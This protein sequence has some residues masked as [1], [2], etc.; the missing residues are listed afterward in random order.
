MECR[1]L[2]P[3]VGPMG[4][5]KLSG[6][7]NF[8]QVPFSV[9]RMFK[10]QN[11]SK[12]A[13]YNKLMRLASTVDLT[14][15]FCTIMPVIAADGFETRKCAIP[16]IVIFKGNGQLPKK[17]LAALN[18]ISG[19]EVMFSLKGVFSKRLVRRFVSFLKRWSFDKEGMNHNT[20]KLF[21]ANNLSC[22]DSNKAAGKL[23]E[24]LLLQSVNGKLKNGIPRGTQYWQPIDR[25]IGE[26]L[27]K[28]TVN[29]FWALLSK[30]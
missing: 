20:P 2:T 30:Q 14:K 28:R 23:L 16:V 7:C 13:K 1:A 18:S 29:D 25:N 26:T 11:C 5:Y 3:T 15:N 27:K 22:Q 4:G 12:G 21:I 19:V 10:R 9:S 24:S 8:D 17:H 6:I